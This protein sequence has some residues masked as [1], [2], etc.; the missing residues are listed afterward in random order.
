MSRIRPILVPLLVAGLSIGVAAC[1]DDS[2]DSTAVAVAGGRGDA[3]SDDRRS[4]PAHRRPSG[5][6]PAGDKAAN[7]AVD[8]INE[9]IQ[10]AGADHT[11]TLV[12]EDDQ[13][14]DQAGV[15]A[16]RKLVSDGASCIAGSWA[17]SVT[18]P[19]ARSVSLR[20]GVLRD[21][22]RLDQRR[23]HRARRPRRPDQPDRP[24]GL[25][26]G[27]DA[28]RRDRRGPRWRRRQDGQHRRPQRLL[29]N[30]PGE[31]V[32]RRLGGPGRNDRPGGH[33]R[34]GGRDVRLR[35]RED[36]RRVTPTRR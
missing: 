23:D 26:P 28:R 18:I 17:S 3:R 35:G 13:T 7:L 29:R 25:V 10:E 12:T 5:L 33:L 11:V 14:S 32:Q 2:S 22:A 4:D 8:K 31:D 30:R 27:P 21:L 6:R 1:G 20:E 34:P 24:A 15:S 16:A 9:A 36:H 19:V